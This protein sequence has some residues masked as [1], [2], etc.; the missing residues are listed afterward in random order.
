MCEP[1]RLGAMRPQTAESLRAAL[2]TSG[3]FA[4]RPAEFWN[5]VDRDWADL[6]TFD[7]EP[8]TREHPNSPEEAVRHAVGQREA[9]ARATRAYAPDA[10]IVFDIGHTDPRTRHPLRRHRPRRWTHPAHHIT[11]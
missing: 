8:E 7:T 1:G 10:T 6:T 9:V 3:A 11:H 2:F 5:D 4:P